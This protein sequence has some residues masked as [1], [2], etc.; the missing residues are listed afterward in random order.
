[1]QGRNRL[2]GNSLV[3]IFVFGRRAGKAAAEYAKRT[4]L[5]TSLNLEHV[6]K[7]QQEL[8]EAGIRQGLRSPLLLPDYTRPEIKKHTAACGA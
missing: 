3:D 6:R 4:E 1:V 5:P 8:A 2:G 7:Y